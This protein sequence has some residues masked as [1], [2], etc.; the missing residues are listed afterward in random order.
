EL[1]TKNEELDYNKRGKRLRTAI[2]GANDLL[3][4]TASLMIGVGAVRTD[5]KSMILSEVAGNEMLRKRNCQTLGMQLEH[6]HFQLLLGAVFIKDY[7]VRVG[8]VNGVV[9][10][11]FGGLSAFLGKTPIKVLL[12]VFD[13]RLDCYGSYLWLN[14]TCW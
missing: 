3:L 2:L 12:K 11:A 4:S 9:N 8:V 5:F 10:F 6:Q 13:R 7:A 1:Q 14:Q